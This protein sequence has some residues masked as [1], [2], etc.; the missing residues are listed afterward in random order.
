MPAFISEFWYDDD[1]LPYDPEFT[2][3][4]FSPC[5]YADVFRAMSR[6]CG[7]RA[8]LTRHAAPAGLNGAVNAER[9]FGPSARVKTIGVKV[10][11]PGQVPA[12]IAKFESIGTPVPLQCHPE[13]VRPD[14][15]AEL[16]R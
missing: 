2:P 16:P 11:C 14:G 7:S 1:A 3:A 15:Q 4:S 12:L 10:L 8:G 5:H 13:V 6:S 9:H